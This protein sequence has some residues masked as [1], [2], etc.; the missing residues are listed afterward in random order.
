MSWKK[1]WTGETYLIEIAVVHELHR[2][3]SQAGMYFKMSFIDYFSCA[4]MLLSTH[5]QAGTLHDP[6]KNNLSIMNLDFS[7]P[8]LHIE[9]LREGQPVGGS[10]SSKIHIR[11]NQVK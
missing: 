6:S 11:E 5:N 8:P 4:F 7:V 2:T 10:S 1:S 3:R 9:L